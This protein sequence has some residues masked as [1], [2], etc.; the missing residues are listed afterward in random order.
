MRGM[1]QYTWTVK[2][3]KQR[4]ENEAFNDYINS[5]VKS[6]KKHFE[7]KKRCT[8]CKT[9]QSIHPINVYRTESWIY[10]DV[11]IIWKCDH[12]GREVKT[13]TPRKDLVE[14]YNEDLK[15]RVTA[16]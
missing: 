9:E 15:K 4:K 5:Y 3:R 2:E 10:T 11:V 13:I 1:I 12:C 6:V 16:K 8:G 7:D 14:W